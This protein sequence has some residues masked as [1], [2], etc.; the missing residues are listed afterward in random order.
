M[1]TGD[2]HQPVF[3]ADGVVGRFITP[4]IID[5]NHVM[6][7]LIRHPVFVWIPAFAG[8]TVFGVFG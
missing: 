6:P 4:A 7:D 3:L 2:A 8:K 1:L 5:T